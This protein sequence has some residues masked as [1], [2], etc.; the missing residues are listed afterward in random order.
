MILIHSLTCLRDGAHA[1]GL[2]RRTLRVTDLLIEAGLPDYWGVSGADEEMDCQ[3]IAQK[4]LSQG[5]VTDDRMIFA[6]K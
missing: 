2:E 4:Q 3:S 1:S 5:R 6:P